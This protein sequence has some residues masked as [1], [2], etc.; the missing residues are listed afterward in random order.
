VGV[1]DVDGAAGVH[2]LVEVVVDLQGAV[3]GFCFGVA[4]ALNGGFE[5]LQARGVRLTVTRS[6]AVWPR[7]VV[8]VMPSWSVT[9]PFVGGIC[10]NLSLGQY[11]RTRQRDRAWVAL[12]VPGVGEQP[13]RVVGSRV[14]VDWG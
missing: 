1:L 7:P 6:D 14:A 5:G 4:G 9:G 11:G 13:G 12:D 10:L 3:D 8:A 2:E